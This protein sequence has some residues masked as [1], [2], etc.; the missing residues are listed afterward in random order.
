MSTFRNGDEMWTAMLRDCIAVSEE[1][2]FIDSR[3]GGTAEVLGWHGTLVDPDK[4]LPTNSIRRLSLAYAGAEVL[5]YLSMTGDIEMIR[6]YAPSYPQWADNEYG[7][8]T[9]TMYGA[10]GARLADNW[11]YV[12]HGGNQLGAAIELLR[13]RP[14][15]RRCVIQLWDGEDLQH[16]I[17]ED[18]K[19]LPCYACLQYII[20]DGAVHAFTY[21]RSNDAWLGAPYDVFAFCCFQRLIADELKLRVGEYHHHV[22]SLHLYDKHGVVAARAIEHA[23]EQ[24]TD[25]VSDSSHRWTPELVGKWQE[26][27]DLCLSLERMARVGAMNDVAAMELVKGLPGCMLRDLLIAA[28]SKTLDWTDHTFDPRDWLMSD[29][30]R[31]LARQEW[32]RK[33]GR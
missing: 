28:M 5:W 21:M 10:V 11:P 12:S 1:G 9:L 30:L 4:S 13:K 7:D 8:E 26:H 16:A 2:N 19:N 27:V 31:E 33:E 29:R 25:E 18:K 15:T 17:T 24:L 32:A 23:D 14:N 3:E 6:Y 22:G 20:R